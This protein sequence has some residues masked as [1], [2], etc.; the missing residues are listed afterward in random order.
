MRPGRSRLAAGGCALVLLMSTLVARPADNARSERAFTAASNTYAIELWDRAERLLGEFAATFPESTHVPDA[1]LLQA[2]CRFQLKRYAEVVELLNQRKA[3][4]GLLGDQFQYWMAEA[5]FARGDYG[6]AATAYAGLLEQFPDSNRRV[7]ASYGQAFAV[8]RSGAME[9]AIRL[10]TEGTGAFAKA[11]ALDPDDLH[12]I[13]GRLLLGEA[14]HKLGRHTEAA[15]TL[16]ELATR[17][18]SREIDWERQYWLTM[19]ERAGNQIEAALARTTNLVSIATATASASLLARSNRVLGD[20]L[21]ARDPDLAAQAFERIARA[22]DAPKEAARQ[23]VLKIVEIRLAQKRLED[24]ARELDDY[25]GR[26]PQDPD[27]DRMRASLGEIHLQRFRSLRSASNNVAGGGASLNLLAQAR[28]QFE[29]VIQQHTNSPL[30]GKA[31]LNLG[32]SHWEET[33]MGGGN[34]RLAAAQRAFTGAAARL[35]KGVEQAAA[36]FKWADCQF[37]QG[38]MTN[39]LQL[40][41]RI[42]TDYADVPA[43]KEDLLDDVLHQI[44]RACLELNDATGARSALD[45]MMKEHARSEIADGSLLLYGG[46]MLR[47]GRLSEAREAF[48]LHR[49][50]YPESPSRAEAVLGLARAFDLEGNP[51]SAIPEY[52][53]WIETFTNDVARSAGVALSLVFAYDRIGN[54]TNALLWQTNVVTRFPSALEAAIAQSWL[55]ELHYGKGNWESAALSYKNSRLIQN[56]NLPPNHPLKL[57]ARLM[58][59]RATLKLQTHQQALELINPLIDDLKLATNSLLGEAYIVRGE[60]EKDRPSADFSNFQS[61]ITAFGLVSEDHPL[62]PLARR[63]AGD[64]YLQLGSRNPELYALAASEYSAVTN[65]PTASVTERSVAEYSLALTLE[66]QAGVPGKSE[67]DRQ[68]LRTRALE[69]YVNLVLGKGLRLEEESEAGWVAKAAE[70]GA[71]LAESLGL[72]TQALRL[73]ESMAALFTEPTLAEPLKMRMDALKK[74]LAASPPGG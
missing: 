34:A 54:E 15:G 16:N 56:T 29:A 12:V 36:R 65:S 23:A 9:Q 51:A 60:I 68:S 70:R 66:Q 44:L 48:A 27:Q 17:E 57:R 31:L 59:A 71:T 67:Q 49:K 24:A 19:V 4:A 63:Q 21:E 26:N 38:G 52:E 61:A 45:A 30:V 72:T 33:Q 6:A 46:A 40:Y 3:V 42:L 43:V 41:R 10:L 62:K 58:T 55:G 20:L 69:H 13:R 64:C 11:V 22:T 8:F 28:A 2:R 1:V 74:K 53:R 25:V 14:L 7:Q 18:L 47:T 73:Y 39:A 32:W 50:N 37:R 35:P 5:E